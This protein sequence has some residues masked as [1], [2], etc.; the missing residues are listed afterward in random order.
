[1]TNDKQ[2]TAL[3]TNVKYELRAKRPDTDKYWGFGNLSV[4]KFGKWQIGMKVTDEL[5]A[6]LEANRGGYINFS[7]NEPYVAK[8]G[9]VAK[10]EQ[11]RES[12]DNDPSVPF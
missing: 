5:I 10:E 7:V 8:E 6:L 4:S 1:M 3:Q 2:A 12:P 11:R 9:F